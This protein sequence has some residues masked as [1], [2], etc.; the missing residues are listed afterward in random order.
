MESQHDH[1]VGNNYCCGCKCGI[2]ESNN[3]ENCYDGCTKCNINYHFNYRRTLVMMV[4]MKQFLERNKRLVEGNNAS[5]KD[6]DKDKNRDIQNE[7]IIYRR[8]Q[9]DILCEDSHE[10]YLDETYNKETGKTINMQKDFIYDKRSTERY[11]SFENELTKVYINE[12]TK[13]VAIKFLHSFFFNRLR[14]KIFDMLCFIHLYEFCNN[15]INLVPDGIK[16]HIILRLQEDDYSNNEECSYISQKIID[17]LVDSQNPNF[18][19]PKQIRM[20]YMNGE[21]MYL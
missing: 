14:N 12:I 20:K 6:K 8:S 18:V 2:E 5:N 16:N 13:N 17:L 10:S 7:D 9:M 15:N 21:I 19:F 1:L 11:V 4:N 3:F